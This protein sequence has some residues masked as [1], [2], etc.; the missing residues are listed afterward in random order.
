MISLT[1]K[2]T[3]RRLTKA[4]THILGSINRTKWFTFEHLTKRGVSFVIIFTKASESFDE[5]SIEE[6][7]EENK[8]DSI[9]SPPRD[10]HPLLT[11]NS[12]P[13]C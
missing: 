5:D 6:E 12:L 10:L 7:V 3:Q 13:L 1:K 2:V 8:T 11:F 4:C 9:E